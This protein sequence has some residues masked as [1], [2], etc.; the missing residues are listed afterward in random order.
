MCILPWL[1]S[2]LIEKSCALSEIRVTLSILTPVSLS[3]KYFQVFFIV[4][5]N[6]TLLGLKHF[7]YKIHLPVLTLQF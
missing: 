7:N 1:R 4:T 2:P 3:V 6:K 5:D